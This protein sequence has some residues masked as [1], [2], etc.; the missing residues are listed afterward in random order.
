MTHA[1][2]NVKVLVASQRSG[3]IRALPGSLPLAVDSLT[4][5][6]FVNASSGIHEAQLVTSAEHYRVSIT[7]R[8][9]KLL[10][11]YNGRQAFDGQTTSGMVHIAEPGTTLSAVMRSPGEALHLQLPTHL[12]AGLG[13]DLNQSGLALRTTIFQLEPSLGL[14][15]QAVAE[16]LTITDT[17]DQLY[18]DG[19]CAAVLARLIGRFSSSSSSR[20]VTVGGL[21]PY[22]LKRVREYIDHRLEKP[23]TLNEL[24]KVADLSQMHFASQFRI[25]IG[26]TPHVYLLNRRIE[27]AKDLLVNTRSSMLEIALAVGFTTHSHFST[28]F[29]RSVGVS[30]ANWRR[31]QKL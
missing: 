31:L 17:L 6:H 13:E 18:V 2:Q 22:R 11:H 26:V 14:L 5:S 24:A 29:R 3:W 16:R 15:A 28:T 4:I 9:S 27:R 10:A 19:L 20:N 12:L 8:G 1:I 25:A 7:L 21:S 30:P 23:I